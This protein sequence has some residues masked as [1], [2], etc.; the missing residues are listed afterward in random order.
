MR[1]S[2]KYKKSILA[3][4][5]ARGGSKGLPRKNIKVF[6]GK[7]LIAYTIETALKSKTIDRLVVSTDVPEIAEISK[8]YGVDVP[9]LRPKSLARDNSPTTDTILHAIN[10]FEK[11]GEYFDI[12]IVLEPTSPLRKDDDIDNAVNFFLKNI[13]RADALVSLGGI[14]LENP[15]LAK[16]VRS[17]YVES[18]IKTRKKFHQRQELEKTYF[19]Y[20]VIYLSKVSTFKLYKT[21][22]QER[23]L[24]F[25]IERWQNYEIDDIYDFIC[26]EEIMKHQLSQISLKKTLQPRK[27]ASL[28]IAGKQIYLK[29]FTEENLYDP[30][31]A[32]WLKDIEVVKTIGRAEYL[33]PFQFSEIENY[34]KRL[35]ESKND[36]FFAIYYRKNQEFIG[37]LKIGSIDWY[38]RVADIGIMIGNRNYWGKGLAKDAVSSAS[39]YAFK[40]LGMRKLIGGCLKTNIA[41][42]K[43]FEE[44]G[45]RREGNRKQQ[46][47]FEGKYVD[48][49]I[50]GMLKEEFYDKHRTNLH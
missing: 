1:Q 15:Y 49:V 32:K 43:C 31:Y 34:V 25:F 40:Y 5:P 21:F 41:M 26:T 23:T 9:F 39:N 44:V 14:H 10:W 42:C 8:K 13:R 28:K 22:Y 36:C 46:I 37:T 45:F 18:I 33:K 35:W 12:V 24:P 7:P 38:N 47:F 2:K 48:H 27:N 4:I 30:K 50:Y 20:G 19:P 11:K 16:I 6:N 17:T 3:V 29:E